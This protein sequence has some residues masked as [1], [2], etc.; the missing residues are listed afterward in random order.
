MD[1]GT[2]KTAIDLNLLVEPTIGM[3]VSLLGGIHRDGVRTREGMIGGNPDPPAE[4]VEGATTG[5]GTQAG[6]EGTLARPVTRTLG[7]VGILREASA[8]SEVPVG[9]STKG[10]PTRKSTPNC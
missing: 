2:G 7:F 8:D 1:L 6:E 5:A 4:R 3:E 10:T 9:M